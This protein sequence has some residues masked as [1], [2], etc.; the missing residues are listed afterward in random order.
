MHG[1]L[2]KYYTNI[3]I[4]IILQDGTENFTVYQWHTAV[5]EVYVTA[6]TY[7]YTTFCGLFYIVEGYT[8]RE[9]KILATTRP[10]TNWWNYFYSSADTFGKNL[11]TARVKSSERHSKVPG[12]EWDIWV[13]QVKVMNQFVKV[14]NWERGTSVRLTFPGKF[15]LRLLLR[16]FV[17]LGNPEK[18]R[19]WKIPGGP[20]LKCLPGTTASA[21]ARAESRS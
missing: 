21:L 12:T 5:L 19:S 13:V 4:I 9:K 16:H 7:W 18:N 20:Y 10:K 11:L 1:T 2:L 15:R 8:S 3:L 17:L 6:V 14:R